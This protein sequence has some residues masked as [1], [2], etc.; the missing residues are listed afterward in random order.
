MAGESGAN[1]RAGADAALAVLLKLAY[2]GWVR[3]LGQFLADNG[4]G[5]KPELWGNF[6]GVVRRRS[7]VWLNSTLDPGWAHRAQ[8]VTIEPDGL[9]LEVTPSDV[10]GKPIACFGVYEY[11][12]TT[13]LRAY[14]KPGDIFVDVGANIGYYSVIAGHIV[15]IGGQVFAFEPSAKIRRRLVRNIALN[16]LSQVNVRAEAVTREAGVVR[17]VEPGNGG[18]DGLAFVDPA[19]IADGV[20]VRAVRL[21]DIF[22]F[23]AH[24]PA[25]LKIDVEGGEPDVFAGAARLLQD[26]NA[27]SLL[28][29]SFE[30]ERDANVLREFDYQVFQPALKDGVLTLAS[31][32]RAPRYRRWEAPNY[33]AVKSERGRMF[34]ERFSYAVIPP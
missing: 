17:L 23:V 11:A 29:E 12:V 2:A 28:F 33:L 4:P 9:L 16:G 14:L 15:G 7:L 1:A 26:D 21:D 30:I 27:P 3:S 10:V 24:P 6:A 32:L 13:L 19:G 22:E 20:D 34:R 5:A 31:D 25:L 18:N 8:I